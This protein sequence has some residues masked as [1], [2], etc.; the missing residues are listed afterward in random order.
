MKKFN[1]L[2]IIPIVAVLCILIT[3]IFVVVNSG[4]KTTP[5]ENSTSSLSTTTT[6]DNS[7]DDT[8]NKNL[9]ATASDFDNLT[10]LLENLSYC[11]RSFEYSS[12]SSDAYTTILDKFFGWTGTPTLYMYLYQKEPDVIYSTEG[13]IEDLPEEQRD[14]LGYFNQYFAYGKVSA[15]ETDWIIENV[16][17]VT[18]D[19]DKALICYEHINE[20]YIYY[21][22]G[23]YYF[24]SG[25][26]G[27]VYLEPSIVSKS[28]TPDYTYT[29]TYNLIS[30]I[31]EDNEK[32]EA[33]CALKEIDGKRQWTFTSLTKIS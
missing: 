18:V 8:S 32:Y 2:L 22:N 21:H 6:Q 13:C 17:N 24:A 27:D 26:G 10:E 16:F 12:E 15:D 25:D 7:N 20:P 5:N 28:N 31:A 29:V 23:Y 3:A 14:P 9:E 30:P 1:V 33:V 19:H 4:I 11:S